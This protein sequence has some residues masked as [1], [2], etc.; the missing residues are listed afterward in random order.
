MSRMYLK[1]IFWKPP[2]RLMIIDATVSGT[3]RIKSAVHCWMHGNS[4]GFDPTELERER[5][6]VIC[7][8]M[9]EGAAA[10]KPEPH[11]ERI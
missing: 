9:G 3:K 10:S 5:H 8:R 11:F 6:L 1:L 2:F 7:I 4:P